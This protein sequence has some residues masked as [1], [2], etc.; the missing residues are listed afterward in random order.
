[1]VFLSGQVLKIEPKSSESGMVFRNTQVQTHFS[2]D[3][4]IGA[5]GRK[6]IGGNGVGKKLGL[7]SPKP[8]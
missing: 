3:S 8:G 2:I 4:E 5:V 7:P 6:V 1:M